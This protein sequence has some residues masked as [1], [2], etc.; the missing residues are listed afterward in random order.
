MKYQVTLC[1]AAHMTD[2]LTSAR[3]ACETPCSVGCDVA[4][5]AV[6][7]LRS[8]GGRIVWDIID[9]SSHSLWQEVIK[10]MEEREQMGLRKY[11]RYLTADSKEVGLREAYEEALDLCVYLKKALIEMEGK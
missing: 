10:D 8:R 5:H 6:A 2:T 9:P 1:S 3:A 11:G 7:E 4:K